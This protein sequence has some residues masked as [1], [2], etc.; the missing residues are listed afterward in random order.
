MEWRVIIIYQP[1]IIQ[2]IRTGLSIFLATIFLTSFVQQKRRGFIWISVLFLTFFLN[3]AFNLAAMVF[4]ELTYNRTPGSI[5]GVSI[6]VS[7]ELISLIRYY[8]YFR[9]LRSAAK[10]QPRKAE[11]AVWLCAAAVAL[12]LSGFNDSW[13]YEIVLTLDTFITVFFLGQGILRLRHQKDSTPVPDYYVLISAAAFCFI[14]YSVSYTLVMLWYHHIIP[15][16]PRLTHS[17]FYVFI[18]AGFTWYIWGAVLKKRSRPKVQN[19]QQDLGL[20]ARETDILRLML[21]GCSNQEICDR[22]YISLGT[23]KAHTHNIFQKL[24]INRRSQ[25]ITVLSPETIAAILKEEDKE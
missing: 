13:K 12:V 2:L 7:K 15:E 22:L 21:Q 10:G 5:V 1:I 23:V 16:A 25:L 19:A 24:N 14:I 4:P 20:T 9:I 11:Q 3:S 17:C 8:S 6:I 18:A